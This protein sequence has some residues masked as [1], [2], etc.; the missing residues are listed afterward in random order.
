MASDN[1]I[2]VL[3]GEP[4]D[5]A[6]IDKDGVERHPNLDKVRKHSRLKPA[7]VSGSRYGFGVGPLF[8]GGRLGN[9]SELLS[10]GN[11]YTTNE[12]ILRGIGYEKGPQASP[13]Q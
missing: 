7:L 5:L 11:K 4:K 6:I 8:Y 9:K 3:Q 12:E 13:P 10:R 1:W 2:W